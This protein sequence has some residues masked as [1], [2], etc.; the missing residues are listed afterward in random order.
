MVLTNFSFFM[1][2]GDFYVLHCTRKSPEKNHA[3]RPRPAA[4]ANE[5]LRLRP[6]LRFSDISNKILDSNLNSCGSNGAA[7]VAAAAQN[8][9]RRAG[10]GR[11]QFYPFLG[12]MSI[13]A[14]KPPTVVL[15]LKSRR[16]AS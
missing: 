5:A 16:F 9:S 1:E 15:N 8:L 14:L 11:Y 13:R 3:N 4:A 12:N 10:S 6:R 7:A 2:F